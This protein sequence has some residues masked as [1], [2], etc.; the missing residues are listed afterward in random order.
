MTIYDVAIA[1][2]G[3]MGGAAA[4]ELGRRGL[5][6][7]GFDRFAPPHALG[8][9]HGQTR[10]IR[11]AYFEQPSYVPMVQRAYTLWRGL[12]QQD[13]RSL[14]RETGGLMI[15][16]PNSA[17]VAGARASAELHRLPHVLLEARAVR[18]RFPVLNPDDDMIAVLEPRA[19]ILLVEDCVQA[20]LAQARRHGAELFEYEP[21]LRWRETRDGVRVVTAQRELLARHLILAAGAWA[22]A[23]LDGLA[24]AFTI[25]R[26]V[27]HW[28]TPTRSPDEFAAD[29]LPIHLWQ[30]DS[31]RFFYGFPDLGAGVKAGFH[32][33]GEVT[34]AD[35]VRREVD[36]AEIE[37]VRK[38]VRRFMPNVD[39]P[40]HASSTCLYTNT[41]DEHFVIDRHPHAAHVVIASACSGHGF[42][43]APVIGEIVADLVQERQSRFDLT[44]F[45]WRW[46]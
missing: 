41:R 34:Q 25:E 37:E 38:V 28:F 35:A 46:N 7:I 10:I 27:L 11:E 23:L 22:G 20:Q 45:R 9:S 39:G 31:G 18:E 33:D 5:R 44:L 40:P 29:R 8:S 24:S 42:K 26:Q 32:H 2:L 36:A 1:G 21:V 3:A 6:V 19:G 43:F 17:L 14:L 13:G 16:S 4:A 15:G 30:F 12:E